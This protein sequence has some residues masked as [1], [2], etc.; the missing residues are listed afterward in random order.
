MCHAQLVEDF[1]DGEIYSNPEW[2]GDV[3]LFRVNDD[4]QLQLDDN[5]AGSACLFTPLSLMEEMEWRCW[6]REAFSPSG[7]NNS[8]IYLFARQTCVDDFPDGIFLQLGEGGS[9]DAIRLM[10]QLDGDTSTLIR[11]EPGAIA[12]SFACSIKTIYKDGSWSLFVDYS[13][14]DEYIPEGNVQ[15]ILPSGNG[16]L[17]IVCKYTISNSTKFY[18]DN[19]YAG[20]IQYDTIPPQALQV[21]VTSALSLEVDFSE[22]LEKASAEN[23]SHYQLSMG[24][25]NPHEAHLKDG[26]LSVVELFYPDTLQY[27]V[28][29]QLGLNNIYDLSGN[30]MIPEMLEFSRY[31]PDRY[32]ILI[33]EIMIDPTP[34]QLLPEYEYLELFN[35]QPLPIDLSGWVLGIGTA[36]KSFS[37]LQIA[38]YAYLIIGKKEAEDEFLPYGNYY[39]FESFALLNTGQSLMLTNE[40]GEL[41]HGLNYGNWYGDDEK[42]D[43]GWAIEQINPYNPCLMSDNWRASSDILGGSPGKQNSVFDELFIPPEIISSCVEDSVRIKVEFNQTMHHGISLHTELF[44]IDHGI[45][46]P[47]AVLPD[48]PYF[49]SFI[50]YPDKPLSRDRIY[51][52]SCKGNVLNCIGDSIYISETMQIGL[53]EPPAWQD[54]VINEILFNPFQGGCDYVEIYNRSEKPVSM[55]GIQLASVRHVPPSPPDTTFTGINISCRQLL[56]GEYVL[57]AKDYNK[58]DDHYFCGDEKCFIEPEGFPSYSNEQGCVILYDA[59]NNILDIFSYHEDMHYPFLN[60]YE[61]V[62]LERIHYNRPASDITNW[63]SA[64]QG[65]GFGTPG[66]KN[67]QFSEQSD[68]KD[69][70][71]ISPKVFTPGYDGQHDHIGIHY[72]FD[73]PGYM[74]TIM[75]VNASGQLIRHLV[76]NE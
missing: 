24:Q 3:G 4:M 45:G 61:G 38:P 11:A 47:L 33:N 72:S 37:R 75:I 66:Y 65:S 73:V 13:G 2:T 57:L 12:Q 35:T 42:A 26:E 34:P 67:S 60:S 15:G 71:W 23:C 5:A 1:S 54:L 9:A 64:S 22:N 50:L 36:E 52:I 70:I 18:F 63:H 19:F 56:P 69:Q 43:G 44:S 25:G 62:S 40:N 46:E 16:Y 7:N 10:Q 27:G 48:D 29:L 21:Y 59:L 55:T 68:D 41:I 17:G 53:P 28:I 49:S 8:R 74:A 31:K 30:V 6:T 58:V 51:Q 39:G 14:G 76:N 32:D 20:A